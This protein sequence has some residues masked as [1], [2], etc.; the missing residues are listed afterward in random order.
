MIKPFDDDM[1]P[2]QIPKRAYFGHANDVDELGQIVGDITV[3]KGK[4]NVYV[5]EQRA[6]LWAAFDAKPIRLDSLIGGH[7]GWDELSG[8][9]K[10][11]S[12]GVISGFGVHNG[13]NSHFIMTPNP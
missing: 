11:N 4:R 6:Y 13:V 7:T 8:A 5:G 9:L 12:S 1:K 2:L 3:S 10:I